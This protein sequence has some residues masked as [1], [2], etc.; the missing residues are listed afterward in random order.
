MGPSCVAAESTLS[1]NVTRSRR[2]DVLTVAVELVFADTNVLVPFSIIDL[3]LG[4]AE[5]GV[6]EFI[7]SDDLLAEWTDNP[8]DE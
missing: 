5:D 4:T 2:D 8:E 3:V 6:H 1:S 7:W